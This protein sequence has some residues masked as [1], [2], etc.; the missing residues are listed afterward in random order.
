MNKIKDMNPKELKKIMTVTER[1]SFT[2]NFRSATA[3]EWFVF[4]PG[5]NDPG[6]GGE[7]LERLSFTTTYMET[8][9]C[10]L[11]QRSYWMTLFYLRKKIFSW[12]TLFV[13]NL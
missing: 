11:T 4:I 3:E 12:F 2:K 6:T 13:M 7:L 8:K 5:F 1:M 9:I 10:S